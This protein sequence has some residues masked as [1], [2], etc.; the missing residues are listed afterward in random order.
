MYFNIRYFDVERN[1]SFWIYI[2][3][4]TDVRK[5]YIW[6]PVH[7]KFTNF[8]HCFKIRIPYLCAIYWITIL[9]KI[10]VKIQLLSVRKRLAL[11][12]SIT[13]KQTTFNKLTFRSNS[14]DCPIHKQTDGLKYSCYSRTLISEIYHKYDIIMSLIFLCQKLKVMG[15]TVFYNFVKLPMHLF[16]CPLWFKTPLR[17]HSRLIL[18]QAARVLEASFSVNCFQLIQSILAPL[19]STHTVHTV[20]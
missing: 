14:E 20:G 15:F 5:K 12:S 10:L 19:T 6:I 7:A 11:L 18:H 9:I 13:F 2:L 8:I 4:N 16:V 3:R 1:I 17:Q